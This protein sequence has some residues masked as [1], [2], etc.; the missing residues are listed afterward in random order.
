MLTTDPLWQLQ[1]PPC[2]SGCA[3]CALGPPLTLPAAS[4]L[5]GFPF[6]PARTP[7]LISCV[8]FVNVCLP[9][10]GLAT[11]SAGLEP[12]CSGRTEEP[13]GTEVLVLSAG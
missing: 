6:P 12:V 2:L 8:A 5:L 3:L 13:L 1:P 10:H 11:P 4:A 9:C 7:D